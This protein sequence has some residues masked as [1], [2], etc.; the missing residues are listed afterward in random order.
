MPYTYSELL[1]DVIA[2]MEEDSDEFLAALPL[3]VTRAQNYLQRRTDAICIN[4][5]TE[6]S[7]SASTR[8]FTLPS[9]LLVLKAIQV[10]TSNGWINLLPQTNEYLTAY[11]P[12]YTSCS[13]PKY[14]APKDNTQI[15]LAPTPLYNNTAL[16]EY[17]PRVTVLSSALPSNWFSENADS[18]FFAATMMYANMWTKNQAAT[19]KWQ[20]SADAELTFI[21]NEA[22]RA[23][24]SDTADRSQGTPENN[25]AESA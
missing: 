16:V 22:R 3:M 25:L 12:D 2:N 8:T 1:G 18:A 19:D 24:R 9:D 21:N 17:V 15:F 20:A 6:T 13:T 7:V 10:S 11:W 23:R 5:F 14:Y 4:R